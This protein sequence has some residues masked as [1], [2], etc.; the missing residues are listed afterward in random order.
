MANYPRDNP[1]RGTPEDRTAFDLLCRTYAG[2]Q[3]S[4]L[5][6]TYLLFGRIRKAFS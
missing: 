1:Y 6:D 3:R 4:R 2:W 5:T